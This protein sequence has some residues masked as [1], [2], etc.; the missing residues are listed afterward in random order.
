MTHRLKYLWVAAGALMLAGPALAQTTTP[1]PGHPKEARP[2]PPPHSVPSSNDNQSLGQAPNSG[3][4]QPPAT[5]DNGVIAPRNRTNAPMPEL[6][7]PGTPGG[8][9]NVEPK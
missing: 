8:N 4:I 9:P 6:R 1:Q 5:G 7:P 3:V 2:V